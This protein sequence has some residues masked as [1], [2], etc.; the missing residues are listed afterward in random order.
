MSDTPRSAF[1]ALGEMA[2]TH[3]VIATL[4]LASIPILAGGLG[5]L[6]GST[7]ENARVNAVQ[8]QQITDLRDRGAEDRRENKE[9]AKELNAKLDKLLDRMGVRP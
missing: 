4:V 1:K 9:V 7:V 3:K 8:D 5:Y 2:A 6:H